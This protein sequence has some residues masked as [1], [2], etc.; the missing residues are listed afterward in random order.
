MNYPIAFLQYCE[1]IDSRI[2]TWR[3]RV[4]YLLWEQQRPLRAY[5]ILAQ[6]KQTKDENITPMTIYRVL[7]YFIKHHVVHKIES[8]QAY[9]LCDF[10]TTDTPARELLMICLQC[11]TIKEF[12]DSQSNSLLEQLFANCNYNMAEQVIELSGICEK[13]R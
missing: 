5:E 3:K 1:H 12:S 11:M 2:T 4:L 9:K 13:C 7:D 6:L 8:I 10:A